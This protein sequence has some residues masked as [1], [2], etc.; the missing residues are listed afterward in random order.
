[1]P[2]GRALFCGTPSP[3]EPEVDWVNSNS[4]VDDRSVSI[5]SATRYLQEGLKESMDDLTGSKDCAVKVVEILFNETNL[6]SIVQ[7]GTIVNVGVGGGNWINYSFQAV[8][9]SSEATTGA[10]LNLTDADG[11][12]TFQSLGGIRSLDSPSLHVVP[13]SWNNVIG[14]VDAWNPRGK[15]FRHLFDDYL[16]SKG[17]GS[18]PSPFELLS[19]LKDRLTGLGLT[20]GEETYLDDHPRPRPQASQR[21]AVLL[22][23]KLQPKPGS[24]CRK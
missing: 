23:S 21:T 1:M 7:P 11:F 19:L 12:S 14:H 5:P 22:P 15:P 16:P 13:Q 24:S 4:V 9:A 17:Y 8:T 3:L 10:I 18:H 2:P 20:I 6:R